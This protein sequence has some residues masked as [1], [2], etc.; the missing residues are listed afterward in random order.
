MTKCTKSLM[1]LGSLDEA[2]ACC[3]LLSC[4]KDWQAHL[5]MKMHV[6]SVYPLHMLRS[7][8]HWWNF[9]STFAPFVQLVCCLDMF[10]GVPIPTITHDKT[11]SNPKHSSLPWHMIIQMQVTRRGRRVVM[12]DDGFGQLLMKIAQE[13]LRDGGRRSESTV[14]DCKV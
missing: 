10:V 12:R 8:V 3:S 13:S 11:T 7:F 5:F 1:V 2:L 14:T 6:C 9:P 4:W